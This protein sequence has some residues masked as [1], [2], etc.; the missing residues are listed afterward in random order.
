[1]DCVAEIRRASLLVYPKERWETLGDLSLWNPEL[2]A[3]GP[4][5]GSKR[6]VR[7]DIHSKLV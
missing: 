7:E 5:D 4:Q 1:M 3:P 2:P 6:E